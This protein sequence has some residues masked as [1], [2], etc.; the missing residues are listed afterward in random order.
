VV[1]APPQ[2]AGTDLATRAME[3]V[4]FDWRDSLPGWSVQF[5]GPRAGLRGATFPASKVVQ[6]Y[7]RSDES[8]ADVA[9]AFAHELGHAIDVTYMDGDERTEFNLA[10]G[11][12][13]SFGWWVAPGAD[14]FSSGAGDWAEC[15]AWTMTQG[16]GGFYSKLG[17]PPNA[18]VMAVIAQLDH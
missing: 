3:L 15:F 16:V 13:A 2:P 1:T 8:A 12:S 6:V 11:R 14:D 18:T 9:H 7:V 5:L 17:P 10:R 4:H